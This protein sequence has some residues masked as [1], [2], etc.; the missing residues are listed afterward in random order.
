[1]GLDPF[2]SAPP[3]G[4]LRAES[5]VSDLSMGAPRV[6]LV[7][8]SQQEGLAY[9]QSLTVEGFDVALETDFEPGLERIGDLSPSLVVLDLSGASPGGFE[10]LL[11]VRRQNKVPI[12]VVT[13]AFDTEARIGAMELGADG[14]IGKPCDCYELATRIR[15]I[16]RRCAPRPAAPLRRLAMS[17]VTLDPGNREVC[18][19]GKTL[20]LTTIEFDILEILMRFAG[21]PVSRESVIRKLYNR[22]AT[23]FDRSV[24]VHISNLRKKLES[25][26]MLIKAVRGTGYQFCVSG[27]PIAPGLTIL[28][29]GRQARPSFAETGQL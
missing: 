22:D 4:G 2:V 14:C 5:S 6:L 1:M 24:N 27:T 13:D 28:D 20:K 9:Q 29:V 11:K 15:A 25:S 8:L 12:L 7:L 26:G 21:R 10:A 16:L 18:V 17:G 19:A 3:M 23:G